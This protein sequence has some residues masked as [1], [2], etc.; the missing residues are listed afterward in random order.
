MLLNIEPGL[1][2]WTVITFVLLLVV[3]RMV[4]WKPILD[5]L[6]ERERR[7]TDAVNQ[8]EKAREE[9]EAASEA[10]RQELDQARADAR[11]AV[12]EARDL[13]E[14]VAQEV[15]DRAEAEA[16]Q[17]LDQAR[18]TIQQERDLAVQELR[19]QVADL[20]ILAARNILDDQI[21]EER[22]RQIVDHLISRLPENPAN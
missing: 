8:A 16:G 9:A 6:D 3:L 1:I 5:A 19:A 14:R 18:T 17:L 4:A 7:I 15:K 13:A 11:Q 12:A 20:A 21:D 10:N 22:G 2:I